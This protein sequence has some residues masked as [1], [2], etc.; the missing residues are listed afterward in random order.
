M[1]IIKRVPSD[2]DNLFTGG[3]SEDHKIKRSLFTEEDPY[4]LL[5][6]EEDITS[7]ENW[8]AYGDLLCNDYL[9]IRDRITDLFSWGTAST[10][11]KDIAIEYFVSDPNEDA[12]TNDINKIMHLTGNGLSQQSA[13]TYLI[14]CYASFHTKEKESCRSRSESERVTQ[15]IITYLTISDARDFRDTID[16]LLGM[17]QEGVIGVDYGQAGVGLIDYID[18][19]IGTV[20]EFAGLSQKGYVLNGGAPLSMLVDDLK[21][22]L[23]NGNY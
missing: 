9:Q 13:Q 3:E 16:G 1:K 6:G 19:T 11:E 21:D 8:V 23:L 17:F 22:V 7:I 15:V 20:Y 5:V 12:T 14:N 2:I 18:G 10:V 4:I